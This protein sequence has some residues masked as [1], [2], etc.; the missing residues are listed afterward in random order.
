[1]T[2]NKVERKDLKIESKKPELHYKCS[3]CD[4]KFNS[5]KLEGAA[6]KVIDHF[7]KVH[8]GEWEE[9]MGL[10]GMA[11]QA[12]FLEQMDDVESIAN[13]LSAELEG[14]EDFEVG[15]FEQLVDE[16]R[17]QVL[18]YLEDDDDEDE[19]EPDE[20]VDAEFVDVLP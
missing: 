11:T 2:R 7:A 16:V 12:I 19:D 6:R 5:F 1:M 13:C 10:V 4:E 9:L 18:S 8:Y 3:L 14:K 17:G 20:I 15:K